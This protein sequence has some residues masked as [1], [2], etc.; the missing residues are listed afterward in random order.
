MTWPQARYL[1]THVPDSDDPL[2]S[3][4]RIAWIA[5]AL[6]NQ[7]GELL[8]GNIFYPERRTLAYSDAVLLQ[9]VAAAPLIWLGVPAVAAYNTL[10]LLS[11]ALSGWAMWL[12]AARVTG[13]SA[14]GVIAG[15]TYAFVPFRFDHFMHLELHAT[16]FL[17]LALLALERVLET[18]SRRDAA[19]LMAATVGQVYSGIYY[20]VFLSTALVIVA[21][22]R[23]RLMDQQSRAAAANALTPAM[24]VAALAVT[25]YLL[26]YVTNRVELGE[27]H[28]REIAMYSAT[29]R[30]YLASTPGNVVHGGWSGALGGP[31]R[32]LFPGFI[33]LILAFTGVA[34]AGRRR[35]TLL[36]CGA[37]G[38]VLSLGFNTPIYDWIRTVLVPY[39]GLR[40]PARAAILVMLAVAGLAAYGFVR[41]TRNRSTRVAR[42]AAIAIMLAMLAE[43]Y[44]PLRSW[45][46]LPIEPPQVYRWLATL[47]P[48]VVAEMPFA[49]ADRLDRIYDG[50]Y[51]FNSTY[52]WQRLVNGYSGFFPGS[53]IELSEAVKGFPDHHAIEQLQQRGVDLIVVHGGLLGPARYGEVTATLMAHPALE[54]AAQFD[55]PGGSDM[56]FRIRR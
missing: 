8:N 31:E 35:V 17:P 52:H 19:W 36:L 32:R 42:T 26:I 5:R 15:I 20:A 29:P 41:L 47:P 2:L 24:I 48:V 34:G 37:V 38:L 21:A 44:S 1:S 11:I 6:P 46:H 7:P 30:H 33:A 3:I 12:Y 13:N 10:V 18:R 53:F 4:W 40:V 49:T 55:E 25:P 43:Y 28:E 56:V 54:P 9:G 16:F 39:R 27:R 45:L 14:A 51:M 50:I 22:F 23:L